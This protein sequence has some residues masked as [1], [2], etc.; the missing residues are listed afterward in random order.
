[1]QQREDSLAEEENLQEARFRQECLEKERINKELQCEVELAEAKKRLL[2][3]EIS[4]DE[5]KIL[6]EKVKDDE[7]F[8]ET[9]LE[10]MERKRNMRKRDK[11][12]E[13][14]RLLIEELKMESLALGEELQ[15]K[16]KIGK[17]K[18]RFL[19]FFC[20]KAEDDE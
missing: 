20:V 9:Y 10:H 13:C 11:E 15:K 14:Q 2:A 8:K 1:M 19:A 17:W 12:I 5:E 7:K 16:K 6:L 3:E 4:S 18:R